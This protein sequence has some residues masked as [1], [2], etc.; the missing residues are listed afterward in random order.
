M[1][2][3]KKIYSVLF[4][5][6]FISSAVYYFGCAS[7]ESTTGKLAFQ[8]KDYEKAEAELKKGIAIDKTDAESWYMLGYSQI[9]LGKIEDAKKES[10]R[11]NSLAKIYSQMI[12]KFTKEFAD[13]F[14]GGCFE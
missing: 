7:A 12:N 5:L 3:H 13:T 8:Q 14:C 6:I 2:F 11:V 1:N 9:E 4:T 10:D